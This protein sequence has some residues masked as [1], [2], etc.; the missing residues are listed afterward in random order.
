MIRIHTWFVTYCSLAFIMANMH[1]E[2]AV[3]AAVVSRA[4]TPKATCLL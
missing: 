1:I 3:P 2:D 4:F